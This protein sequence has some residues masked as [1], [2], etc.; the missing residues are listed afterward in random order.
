M[1]GTNKVLRY[2]VV[3]YDGR[4]YRVLND[5]VVSEHDRLLVRTTSDY[6]VNEVFTRRAD[7]TDML[8]R[9]NGEL[10][11]IFPGIVIV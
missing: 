8:L 10:V 9:S 6:E 4:H 3:N 2:S 1:I 7:G 11:V 5:L